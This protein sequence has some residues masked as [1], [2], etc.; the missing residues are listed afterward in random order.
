MASRESEKMRSGS[1]VWSLARTNGLSIEEEIELWDE[2][3][4][5][6]TDV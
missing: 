4:G 3:H 6:V 2:L 5:G 1:L